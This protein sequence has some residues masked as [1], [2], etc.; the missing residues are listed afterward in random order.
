MWLLW[1]VAQ[2]NLYFPFVH[3]Y[4]KNFQQCERIRIMGL[5]KKKNYGVS[6][7]F[8]FFLK[9]TLGRKLSKQ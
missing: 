8:V 5:K 1:I 7:G 2:S 4:L 6:F 3:L 9:A